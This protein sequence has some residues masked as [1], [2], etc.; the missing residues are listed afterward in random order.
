MHRWFNSRCQL[1]NRPE[2]RLTELIHSLAVRH[3]CK[4]F[5]DASAGQPQFDVVR[6][7][8]RRVLY[9]LVGNRP[10]WARRDQL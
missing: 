10:P 2:D 3:L 8:D 7:V 4:G 6:V 5:A 1:L 9:T